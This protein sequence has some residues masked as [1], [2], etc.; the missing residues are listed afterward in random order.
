MQVQ[1]Q[2]DRYISEQPRAKAAEL[3]D[4]HRRV[5]HEKRRR[6]FDVAVLGVE[7][8]H[9]L[10]ERPRKARAVASSFLK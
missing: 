9:E 8:E 4:L 6:D 10:D 1:E 7:L 3:Q 2:I 5:L